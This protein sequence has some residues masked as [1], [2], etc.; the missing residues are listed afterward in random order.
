MIGSRARG[1]VKDLTWAPSLLSPTRIALK[2]IKQN[3][4]SH[5]Y[6]QSDV[7]NSNRE[8]RSGVLDKWPKWP[9]II[10]QKMHEHVGVSCGLAH[11]L[12][13]GMILGDVHMGLNK[14]KSLVNATYG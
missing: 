6:C 5:C 14:R 2:K 12:F 3:E 9:T 1:S 13:D 10:G 11:R 7:Q 4:A 8:R